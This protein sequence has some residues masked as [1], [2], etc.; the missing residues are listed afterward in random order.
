MDFLGWLDLVWCF[1]ASTTLLAWY[2]GCHLQH[3][4]GLL[5]LSLSAETYTP[6]LLTRRAQLLRKRDSSAK[7]YAAVELD[8]KSL[9]QTLTVVLIRPLRLFSEPMILVTCI[10]LALLFAIYYLFFEAYP[11]I[12]QGRLAFLFYTLLLTCGAGVYGLG[13]NASL[14]FIPSKAFFVCIGLY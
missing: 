10:F 6:V 5:M 4:S 2:V 7:I 9:K 11:I 3:S 8:Q 14:A 13:P 12:F 1:L